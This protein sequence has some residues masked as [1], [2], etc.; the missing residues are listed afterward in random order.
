[1]AV[2]RIAIVGVGAIGTTISVH[3]ARTRRH[4]ITLCARSP[5][6][7]LSLTTGERELRERLPCITAPAAAPEVDWILL[8]TKAHQTAAAGAWLEA[9]ARPET[10]I[11]VLQNGVDHEDRVRPFA[12]AATIVPVIVNCPVDRL[13]S[14][15][16]RQRGPARLTV[17]DDEPG[18]RF[19]SLAEGSELEV[20]R[21]SDFTTAAWT[22][23]VLN[24]VG[25]AITALTDRPN[26][27]FRRAD[28]GA[29]G[30]AMMLEIIRVGRAEGAKLDDALADATVAA[31]QA[32][33]PDGTPSILQDRR[34]GRPLEHDARNGVVVRLGRK[35][36]IPTPLCEM[37][38]TLL[39]ASS[40]DE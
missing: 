27:V 24:A 28:V 36:G 18:A 12:G 11:A 20:A 26:G 39:A 33:S 14:G 10:S 37:A 9:M 32:G 34:A 29:L 19:A 40:R 21:A 2:S 6:D 7:E 22:K 23:L 5:I 17:R 38:A 15:R 8:A 31:L 35:H 4:A 30:T 1:M 25:G 13:A 3:L 16:A